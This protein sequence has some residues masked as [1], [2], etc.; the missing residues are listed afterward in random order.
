MPATQ[1]APAVQTPTSTDAPARKSGKGR[2]PTGSVD[3]KPKVKA[4][5]GDA[6]APA[7]QKAPRTAKRKTHFRP[8]P[9]KR[10][11]T[12]R[13]NASKA[14][15][16]HP[17][18]SEKTENLKLRKTR[19]NGAAIDRLVLE[20][21]RIVKDLYGRAILSRKSTTLHGN[22]LRR[23]LELQND[24][25]SRETLERL[26]NHTYDEDKKAKKKRPATGAA[27]AAQAA[28]AGTPASSNNVQVPAQMQS[29]A[30][31]SGAK[32]GAVR[33]RNVEVSA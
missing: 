27:A 8:L 11:V 10:Y 33:S 23:Q 28:A 22:D 1:V 2:K 32:L 6:A 14:T 26:N 19:L 17:V 7:A 31:A 15:I 3:A 5:S 13:V 29:G 21:E 30:S 25:I 9:F 12:D 16:T 24:H 18:R 20:A 4:V